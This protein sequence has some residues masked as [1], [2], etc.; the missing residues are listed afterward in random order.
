MKKAANLDFS[1]SSSIMRETGAVKRATEQ[2][3]KSSAEDVVKTFLKSVDSGQ[4]SDQPYR[5]WSLKGCF[6]TDTVDD[7]LALPF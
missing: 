4:R 5:N 3:V 2:G 7:I 6:P 1:R